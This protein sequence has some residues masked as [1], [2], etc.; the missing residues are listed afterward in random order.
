MT[1]TTEIEG[2]LI[3]TLKAKAAQLVVDDE[4]FVLSTMAELVPLKPPGRRPG[5]RV[6][7]AAAAVAA[8]VALVTGIALVRADHRQ[9]TVSQSDHPDRPGVFAPTWV[10]DGYQLWDVSPSSGPGSE[11]AASG[12]INVQ[13]FADG[14]GPALYVQIGGVTAPGT[15]PPGDP[16]TVHGQV[17]GV[18]SVQ[19]GPADRQTPG[20]RVSIRWTEN[21]QQVIATLIHTSID[22]AVALLDG[23]AWQVPDDPM[24]GVAAASVS[25]SVSP[26]HLAGGFIS[27][28]VPASARSSYLFTTTAPTIGETGGITVTATGPGT[29]I[30]SYYQDQLDGASQQADATVESTATLPGSA[31]ILAV[32]TWPDGRSS[33]ASGDGIDA[34][35]LVRIARSAAPTT[36]ADLDARRAQITDRILALPVVATTELPPLT[37]EVHGEG[38]TALCAHASS[39]PVSCGQV[40]GADSID[41]VG[42]AV[43]VLVD[44]DWYIGAAGTLPFSYTP[45]SHEFYDPRSV[46]TT[47]TPTTAAD[48]IVS[49]QAEQGPWHFLVAAVP[50][51]VSEAAV[52][53][54]TTNGPNCNQPAGGSCAEGVSVSR[55]TS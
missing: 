40:A 53:W 46:P 52:D 50:A 23:L 25:T 32:V 36:D 15:P 2:R 41:T 20:Q 16:I 14:V 33:M 26:L 42:L 35:D 55:P 13:L 43:S 19:P 49:H 1:D 10:P 30:G 6:L 29:R 44:G 5:G 3:A 54:D 28:A 9:A 37:L 11:Q 24:S 8:V 51:T 38:G 31:I 18:T 48:L 12:P 7:A 22:R 45:V 34:A 17:G 39:G 4:P 27:S 21:G 47:P